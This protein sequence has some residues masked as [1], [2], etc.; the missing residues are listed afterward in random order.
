MPPPDI[1]VPSPAAVGPE[2]AWQTSATVIGALL[3]VSIV[4]YIIIRILTHRHE[5]HGPE[6]GHLP[7]KPPRKR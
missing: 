1:P 7:G 3:A 4:I 6:S 2:V 5:R